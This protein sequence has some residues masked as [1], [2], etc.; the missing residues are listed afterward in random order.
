LT[1]L[2]HHKTTVMKT[3]LKSL[4]ALVAILAVNSAISQQTGN[5]SKANEFVLELYA[6]CPQYQNE[7]QIAKATDYLSRTI[8]HSVALDEYP[9]CALLSSVPKKNKCNLDI[10][11]SLVSFDPLSFNPLVYQ[12]KYFDTISNYYRVDG[13][14]Y[15]IEIKPKN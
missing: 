1:K 5:V 14:D 2:A 11:Y 3:L 9:E 8:I 6:N 12:F 10:D 13:K 4:L 15:I 7:D